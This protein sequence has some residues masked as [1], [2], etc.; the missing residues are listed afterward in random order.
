MFVT[1]FLRQGN[2]YMLLD[3]LF[4]RMV[5]FSLTFSLFLSSIL[6]LNF[7]WIP[8]TF[9]HPQKDYHEAAGSQFFVT[10]H[11]HYT[12]TQCEFSSHLLNYIFFSFFFCFFFTFDANICLRLDGYYYSNPDVLQNTVSAE[13]L[14]A[15]NITTPIPQLDSASPP[16][17]RRQIHHSQR[18]ISTRI[19]DDDFE[20]EIIEEDR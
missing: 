18:N 7:L 9:T 2:I 17:H 12:S 6:L 16:P 19:S 8:G 5:R 14:R 15:L 4:C 10:T 1:I 13:M 20:V 3:I 11:E